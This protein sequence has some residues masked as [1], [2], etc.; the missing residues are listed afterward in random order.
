MVKL[1]VK[2]VLREKGISIGKLSRLSDV[3]FSTCRRLANDPDYKPSLD[4]LEKIANALG[5]PIN[6][7][8]KEEDK[9]NK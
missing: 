8:Y 3:S 9:P 7:L 4:T 1:R 2:Q 6:D 5:V